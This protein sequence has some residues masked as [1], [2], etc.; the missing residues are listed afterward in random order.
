MTT[1]VR[2]LIDRVLTAVNDPDADDW[3]APELI[4]YL[5]EGIDVLV[6]LVPDQFVAIE[7]LQ[8][9]AGVKQTLPAQG[10]RFLRVN[11]AVTA[12]DALGPAAREVSLRALEQHYPGWHTA[13]PGLVR[14]WAADPGEPTTFW[15]N[16]PQ[17][18]VAPAK[19]QVQYVKRP[20]YV[21]IGEQLPVDPMYDAAL[22]EY[23]LYRAYSKDA[24]Y[25]GQDGRANMHYMNFKG[26]VGG[27]PQQSG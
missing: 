20:E 4:G 18:A 6:T 22:V 8:L 15:V 17:D 9:V 21:D 11:R 5:N 24:D 10:F 19:A 7:T 16:P 23:V 25:A 3:S 2:D 14:E 26:A 1:T 12:A 27:T 13:T